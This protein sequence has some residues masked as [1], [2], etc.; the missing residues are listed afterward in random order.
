MAYHKIVLDIRLPDSCEG[1]FGFIA[2]RGDHSVRQAYIV[3]NTA[4]RSHDQHDNK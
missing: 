1:G 4:T 2:E 3:I